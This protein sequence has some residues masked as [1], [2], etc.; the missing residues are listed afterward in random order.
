MKTARILIADDHEIVRRG[1]R[2]ILGARPDWEVVGEAANGRE[3]VELARKL[4]PDAVVLDIAMPELNGLEATHQIL[5][6][7]PAAE[8]LILSMHESEQL[9]RE[10]LDAGARGYVLK[11]DAGRDLVGA[12]EHVLQH[13]PAFTSKVANMVLEGYLTGQGKKDEQQGPGR[14]TS[15]EREIV[16]LL[17]EGKSNKD[18]AVALD[19]SVKTVEAH[20]SNIMHKLGLHSL[21]DIVHYAVRNKIVE[22]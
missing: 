7:A 3:A 19:I 1:L 13:R 4:K 2:V 15:R 16:Q 18:V 9:V 21:S 6:A 10:V 17:A 12:I 20:R 8:V 14:L 22:P 11:S 5:K